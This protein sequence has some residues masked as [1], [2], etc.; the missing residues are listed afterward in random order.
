M[1]FALVQTS[2]KGLEYVLST[3]KSE[4]SLK[5]E[6]ELLKKRNS[7]WFQK[8]KHRVDVYVK[9]DKLVQLEG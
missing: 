9:I 1:L 6:Y 2:P 8:C 7:W 5:S 4:S 3:H